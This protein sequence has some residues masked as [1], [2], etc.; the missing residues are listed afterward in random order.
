MLTGET[1]K[2]YAEKMVAM[3]S[4]ILKQ[5]YEY[6]LQ[7]GEYFEGALPS[8]VLPR[9]ALVRALSRGKGKKW[10]FYN[11]QMLALLHPIWGIEYYEGVADNGIFIG[12]HAWN[13]YQGKVIDLTWEDIPREFRDL[14]DV[15][16]LEKFQYF[17][18]KIPYEFARTHNFVHT[19][20]VQP[21]LFEYLGGG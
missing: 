17:G 7:C 20:R 9:G 2:E 10:C 4:G 12:I 21:L 3:S 15:R 8:T 13:L 14:P 1:V 19:R 6:I 18:V 11:A 5:S 16:P